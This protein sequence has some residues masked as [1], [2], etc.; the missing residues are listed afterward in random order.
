MRRI[1]FLLAFVLFGV[2][3][4]DSM[5]L[6]ADNITL[7][8]VGDSTM[9]PRNHGTG[10]P[11]YGWGEAVVNHFDDSVSVRNHAVGGES[12]HSFI[13][14]GR[15]QRA[16]DKIQPG[17]WVVIQ[18]GHNDQKEN[19]PKKYASPE[20]YSDNL[21]RMVKEVQERG[22]HVILATSIER[23]YFKDNGDLRHTLGKYPEAARQTAEALDLPMADLNDATRAIIIENGPEDSKRFFLHFEPGEHPYYPDGHH[24]N[25]HLS[26]DGANMV[27]DE[28]IAWLRKQD[29]ELAQHLKD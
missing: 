5:S 22:G 18:F 23:L 4:H 28:F 13:E 8:L 19:R 15:W 21:V 10:N 26:L 25:S 29:L 9:A 14:T 16:L 2:G 3:L 1:I 7:H 17:D 12:T 11:E 24:D 6:A 20:D 27:A